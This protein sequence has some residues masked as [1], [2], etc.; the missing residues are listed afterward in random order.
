MNNKVY[1]GII[2][3]LLLAIAYLGYG[4]SKKSDEI[5]V[6]TEEN[7]QLEFDRDA[8]Q[9]DL[10]KM[11]FSYDTLATENS[12]LMAEMADQRSQIDEL[13]KKV[14]DKNWS[15]SKLK[16]ETETLR[17][18]MKGYIFTIDSLNQLNQQLMADNQELTDRVNTVEGQNRDLIERQEN[19]EGMIETGQILQTSQ[20]SA[21]AI[22]LTNSGKQRETTRARKAE[23][24]KACF[25]VMENRIAKPGDKDIYLRVIAPDGT[26]LPSSDGQASREFAEEGVQYYS[27]KRNIDYNNAQMDVC[28]FY[29]VQEG[30]ELQKGDYKMFVYEGSNRIGTIDMVLK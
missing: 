5:Q 14:K 1:L 19:M 13:L 24:L 26:V 29:T 2:A 9:L 23:M 30:T 20:L 7:E 12:L 11:R 3:A 25:T 4:L 22:Q 6:K 15:I 28:V 17:E 21:T 16:K 10:E 18:I 27:V 8:L